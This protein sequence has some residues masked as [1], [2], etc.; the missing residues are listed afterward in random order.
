MTGDAGAL[1][2]GRRRTGLMVQL[3][4]VGGLWW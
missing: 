3:V 2:E 4:A 1:E